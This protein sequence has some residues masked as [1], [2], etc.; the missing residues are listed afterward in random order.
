MCC[1]CSLSTVLQW[2]V[3]LPCKNNWY[4]VTCDSQGRVYDL[5]LKRN[6]YALSASG[7]SFHAVHSS[8]CRRVTG[9]LPDSI[10]AWTHK[11]EIDLSENELSG[12]KNRTA[13]LV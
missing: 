11:M 13:R 3:G 9:T 4:G 12:S 10:G 8:R 1:V 2:L 7:L 6:R 5:D